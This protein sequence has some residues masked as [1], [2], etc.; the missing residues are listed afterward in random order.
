M[1][2]GDASGLAWNTGNATTRGVT[3]CTCNWFAE[4]TVIDDEFGSHGSCRGK[5]HDLMV[6]VDRGELV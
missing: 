3:G 2:L 6:K 4:D 5:Y 1:I